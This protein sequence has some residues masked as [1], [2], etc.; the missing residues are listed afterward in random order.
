MCPWTVSSSVEK[1]RLS[2]VW[3]KVFTGVIADLLTEK[4]AINWN[5]EEKTFPQWKQTCINNPMICFL[6]CLMIFFCKVSDIHDH[7]TW[8]SSSQHLYMNFHDTTRGQKMFSYC[9]A[10]IWNY[11]LNEKDPNCSIGVFKKHIRHIFLLS[12]EDV[13]TKKWHISLSPLS[14]IHFVLWYKNEWRILYRIMTAPCT[15][16]S[17]P[18]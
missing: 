11:I 4:T 10:T 6:H 17:A 3:H 15:V 9:D 2:L 7:Y 5:I 1:N 8:K 16:C 13:S 14:K 12:S 18:C